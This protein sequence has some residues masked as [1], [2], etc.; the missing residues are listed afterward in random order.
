M[1]QHRADVVK[2]IKAVP[3]VSL[4]YY[5][6][7]ILPSS[8]YNNHVDAII[9]ALED[10]KV[11]K[12]FDGEEGLRWADFPNDP[13]NNGPVEDETFK[14]MASIAAAIV[15]A[16]RK[17]FEDGPEPTTV[18]E[19]RPNETALSE[20]RNGGF[21]SDGHYRLLKS[22]RPDYVEDATSTKSI[23]PPDLIKKNG[24]KLACDRPALEEYKKCD[25]SSDRNDDFGKLVGNASQAM[26]CRSY[27][28]IH[29]TTTRFW[30]FSRAI[31]L[32][33]EPFNFIKE[34]THLIRYVLS[35]SFATTEELGYDMSVTRVAYPLA[36]NSSAHTIQYDYHIGGN[37]YRTVDCLSS[38]RASGLLSRATR[39]WTVCQINEEGHPQYALKDVWVPSNAKTELEIQ[40]EI[41]S[42]IEKHHPEIKPEYRTKYFMKILKCEVV[43]T[44]QND[45]DDM[46]VFV[47]KPLEII[48]H[49]DLSTTEA[50]NV[51]R[52]MPGSTI[53]TPTGASVANPHADDK[54]QPSRLYK[55]RKHVRVIFADVGTPLSDIRH[56]PVLFKALSDALEGLH[57]LYMGHYVHRDISAGNIIICDGRAKI[58]DLEYAKKGT[59][60]Y[61]AVEVQDA[62]YLFVQQKSRPVFPLTFPLPKRPRAPFLHNYLHDV[63][64]LLW[65]GFH[66][67]FSTVPATYPKDKLADRL[68]Q[69]RL[70]DAF[71]PHRLDGSPQRR[72]FFTDQWHDND[73]PMEALPTEYHSVAVVLIF[74]RDALVSNYEVLENLKGFP[75][76]DQFN[77][78]YGTEQ[79]GGL[80]P[81]FEAA[82]KRAYDG[83]TQSLFPDEAIIIARPARALVY[84][85]TTDDGDRDDDQTYVFDELEQAAG[86]S[87][88]PP[89][90]VRRKN[91]KTKEK[92]AG[93]NHR[94]S[95]KQESVEGTHSGEKRKRSL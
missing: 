56:P 39:V 19:C 93:R 48:G 17:V 91:G 44:S 61:M 22:R 85:E 54:P 57:H 52:T 69:H 20:G 80:L 40:G 14:Y 36:A 89:S 64:S 6:N 35:L 67:L 29:N 46:P 18:M 1:A 30:F 86:D 15:K 13:Q 83:D 79:P 70:F 88:E 66:A 7:H 42:S 73:D 16:A 41:F 5:E 28:S 23:E 90:K 31:A 87:E 43:Q 78:I 12:K 53:S 51:S 26:Y 84:R 68:D 21:K 3:Q 75:Q 65:I 2:D 32:V 34:Y 72:R 58:S 82:A 49:L 62:G 38:F 92:V 37:T 50:A 8:K 9:K 55:G 77:Q 47:R 81:P 4:E 71:F 59:P 94:R 76:H 33:S 74:I 60:I 45:D 95:L 63:E 27:S 10:D 11:L 25:T 24:H